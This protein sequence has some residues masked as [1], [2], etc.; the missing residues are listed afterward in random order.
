MTSSLDLEL[1][2]LG[3]IL[4]LLLP[5]SSQVFVLNGRVEYEIYLYPSYNKQTDQTSQYPTPSTHHLSL[6]ILYIK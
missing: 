4:F 3:S 1:L 5:K 6:K 2:L